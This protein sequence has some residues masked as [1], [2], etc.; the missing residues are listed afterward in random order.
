MTDLVTVGLWSKSREKKIQFKEVLGQLPQ[1]SQ[2]AQVCTERFNVFMHRKSFLAFRIRSLEA[3]TEAEYL[4]GCLE[5]R[6][7][8]YPAHSTLE[9]AKMSI[10]HCT[11]ALLLLFLE[12][13]EMEKIFQERKVVKLLS[14]SYERDLKPVNHHS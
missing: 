7:L 11:A 5:T 12:K 10:Q 14:K 8:A 3:F 1:I 6:F 9:I 13:Y 2:K 4:S